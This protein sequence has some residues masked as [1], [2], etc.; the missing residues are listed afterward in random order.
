MAFFPNNNNYKSYNN[1]FNT[2]SFSQINNTP[3]FQQMTPN[4]NNQFI[5]NQISP[6]QNIPTKTIR[7]NKSFIVPMS[8]GKKLIGYNPN[9][10]YQNQPNNYQGQNLNNQIPINYLYSSTTPNKISLY[11]NLTAKNG[12]D[13][14]SFLRNN[15]HYRR[16]TKFITDKNY[17]HI[18]C[19]VLL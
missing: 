19:I 2:Q 18:K 1:I 4:I 3:T 17:I 9:N 16:A 7:R 10:I 8:Y 15:F 11:S 13:S 12:L 14:S 5:S 6:V